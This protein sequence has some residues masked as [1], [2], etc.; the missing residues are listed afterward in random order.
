MCILG[1]SYSAVLQRNQE[2]DQHAIRAYIKVSVE[3]RFSNPFSVF[4]FFS[5]LLFF[6]F[7]CKH[8]KSNVIL[9]QNY[10]RM[11]SEIIAQNHDLWCLVRNKIAC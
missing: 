11:F 8:Q 9:P 1:V 7:S 4:F 2:Y 6:F 3:H 5:Y 10:Q